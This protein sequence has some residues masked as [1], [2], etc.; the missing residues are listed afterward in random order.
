MKNNKNLKSYEQAVTAYPEI[1][2]YELNSDIEFIVMACD[3]IWDCVDVQKFCEEISSKIKSYKQ[4]LSSLISN[5]FDVIIS[6]T[7]DC[8]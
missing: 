4:Q 7:K 1:S 5:L 8:K 3:G 2:V 6:K